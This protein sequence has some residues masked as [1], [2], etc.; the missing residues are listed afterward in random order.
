MGGTAAYQLIKQVKLTHRNE[1]CWCI[2]MYG[3]V[4]FMNQSHPASESKI[5]I[6]SNLVFTLFEHDSGKLHVRTEFDSIL[7]RELAKIE[8]IKK[9][10]KKE[11]A[12]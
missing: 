6:S 2:N 8:R 12:I 10:I 4:I 1:P 9:N 7:K 11:F 5:G 3:P